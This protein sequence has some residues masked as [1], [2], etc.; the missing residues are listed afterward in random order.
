MAVDG[1]DA[2]NQWP[3]IRV[4]LLALDGTGNPLPS[5]RC[6]SSTSTAYNRGS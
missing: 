5:A 6:G 4:R 2:I 1:D 3:E